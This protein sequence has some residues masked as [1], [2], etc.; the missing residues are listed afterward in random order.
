M[1]IDSCKFCTSDIG[2][3]GDPTQCRRDPTQ[4]IIE[5]KIKLKKLSIDQII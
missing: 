4:F 5:I 2:E 3:T 1:K